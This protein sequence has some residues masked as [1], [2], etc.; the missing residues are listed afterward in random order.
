MQQ[1]QD[2]KALMGFSIL[3]FKLICM[4]FRNSSFMESYMYIY[5]Y[6][7][8]YKHTNIPPPICVHIKKYVY[9]C[10]FKFNSRNQVS[11]R[12]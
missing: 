4:Y 6:V 1:S 11:S 12:D 7:C 8:M 3:P 5:M 9:V 10:V 2:L